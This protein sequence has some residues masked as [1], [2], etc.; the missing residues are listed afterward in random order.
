MKTYK[1]LYSRLCSYE[2]LELAF[3]KARKRKTRKGYVIEFEADL[4]KNLLQLK[5]ELETFAY[6]PAPLTLFAIRDPKTRRISASHFRDRVVHHA[7][8]NVIEPIFDR[9]FI[10]D[11]FANRKGKGTHAAILRFEHFL[12]KMTHNGRLE[13]ENRQPFRPPPRVLTQM[14]L[15]ATP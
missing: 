7:L 14:T 6:R 8:C 15:S 3:R 11:S 13:T 10:Y 5:Q 9:N 2:N 1:R 12:R 4:E